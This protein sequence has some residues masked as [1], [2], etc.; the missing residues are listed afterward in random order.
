M[1]QQD[2]EI[3]ITEEFYRY[4]FKFNGKTHR[5]P[6]DLAISELIRF[7]KLDWQF[8]CRI[9]IC[10]LTSEHEIGKYKNLAQI[11]HQNSNKS[12][13]DI[14]WKEVIK[15]VGSGD[16]DPKL[17][18]F[19][20]L[21]QYRQKLIQ[22]YDQESQVILRETS[23]RVISRLIEENTNNLLHPTPYIDILRKFC[24]E[25]G[26]NYHE[27]KYFLTLFAYC[28][29]ILPHPLNFI[30][31]INHDRS[32]LS[33]LT[34]EI[35]K[36]EGSLIE[37]IPSL[38]HHDD[39]IGEYQKRRNEADKRLHILFSGLHDPRKKGLFSLTNLIKEKYPDFHRHKFN[40]ESD[41]LTTH[42]RKRRQS[43]SEKSEVL[44]R[45]EFCYRFRVELRS[46]NGDYAWNC[47]RGECKK[48]YESWKRHLSRKGMGLNDIRKLGF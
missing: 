47:D 41:L 48:L 15:E 44:C 42:N 29:L 25:A 7:P 20:S 2:P 11:L 23:D 36:Y 12:D 40:H 39:N 10:Q 18:A 14:L 30:R 46:S 38:I 21:H 16:Y 28:S 8:A 43:N 3:Q 17:Y 5:I 34:G 4:D 9:F 37:E 13:S 6:S 22:E 32:L 33:F 45:C 26:I 27:L 1:Q 35:K 24:D 31:N 19:F